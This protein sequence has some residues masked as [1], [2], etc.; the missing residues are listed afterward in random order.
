MAPRGA[1]GGERVSAK[2][3]GL[4][5]AYEGRLPAFERDVFV[6]DGASIVGDVVIGEGSSVWYGT[7]LR[8]DVMPIRVGRRTNLQDLTA[9]HGTTDLSS[10]TLGDEVTV[11]H[12]VVLHGCTVHDRVLVGMGSIVLDL[13]VVESDVVIGAGSLVAPRSRLESGYL[14]LGSPVK[15]I[16][17]LRD[18]DRAM[19]ETGWKSY[20]DLAARH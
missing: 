14:Y 8:G 9:V 1:P 15:R 2:I 7:V 10:T 6:A 13:A 4:V 19:I 17:P 20:V 5:R 18:E 11:G 3:R 16:R 12:R